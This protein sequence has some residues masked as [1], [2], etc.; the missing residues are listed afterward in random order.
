M[1]DKLVKDFYLMHY[2]YYWND[3]THRGEGNLYLE[4]QTGAGV[5]KENIDGAIDHVTV[6]LV[7]SLDTNNVVVVPTGVFYLTSCTTEEFHGS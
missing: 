4:T 3:G 7:N 1:T 6:G 2:V 5:R